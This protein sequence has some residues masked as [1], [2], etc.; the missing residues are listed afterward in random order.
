MVISI[1]DYG[2]GNIASIYNMCSKVGSKCKIVSTAQEI[3]KADALII[4]GVGKFD[5]AINLI[6]S[7]DL[8]EPLN[9]SV[10]NRGIPVLGICLGM[11]LMTRQS[12]EGMQPGFSWIDAQTSKID[13]KHSD[14]R[15]P[16]MGWNIINIAKHHP[17]L[18]EDEFP[19]HRFYFVHSYSVQC[20]DERDIL[21]TSEYGD[22]FV[23]AFS[24]NNI[25]GVQFHPEKS[26]KFGVSLFH[27]FS[28]DICNAKT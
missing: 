28:T 25:I 9:Y 19:E 26:H 27:K 20:N 11:Q 8:R 4:P 13:I 10:L 14:L 24:R 23:S 21:A 7:K 17:V 5:S 2:C 15:V 1:L 6:D 16:H 12:E 3:Q 18:D 22:S